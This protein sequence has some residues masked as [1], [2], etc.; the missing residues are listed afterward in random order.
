MVYLH[1]ERKCESDFLFFF[2]QHKTVNVRGA[3]D[4]LKTLL[5]K[6]RIL[7]VQKK[8]VGRAFLS[9]DWMP[10]LHTISVLY[11]GALTHNWLQS[12]TLVSVCF[13]FSIK[14][15]SMQFLLHAIIRDTEMHQ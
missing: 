5:P 12:L 3:N 7:P 2:T 13:N 8:D 15:P 14:N 11:T 1:F 6:T 9:P 10:N 4:L